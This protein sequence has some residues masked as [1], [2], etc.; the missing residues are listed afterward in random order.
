MPVK[1]IQQSLP[2]LCPVSDALELLSASGAESRG[3]VFTRKEVVDFMLD[4]AGYLPSRPLHTQRALEPSFG[5]GDFLL[6][7]VDRLLAAARNHGAAMGPAS[8]GPCIRAV[9]L[10]GDSFRAT[11][12]R[13]VSR[14][15]EAGVSSPD[16]AALAKTWL[17]E[18]DFLLS[19]F[20][21][22]FDF[23]VGNPPYVRQEMI[24][25]PLLRVYRDLFDTIYDRADLYIPFIEKSLGLLKS[26]GMLAFICSDRWMKN[27]YGSKLRRFVSNGYRLRYFVDMVDTDA[28]NVPVIAYPAITVIE[29]GGSGP[30]RLASR[31]SITKVALDSLSAELVGLHARNGTVREAE[32]VVQG[33]QPWLLG[34]S[35]ELGLVRRLEA[36]FPTLEEA[37]CQVGI[38][39]AT[40][41]DRVYIGPYDMLDVEPDRKLPLVR[42]KDI[43]SGVVNWLGFGV[44]NPFRDDGGLVDLEQYP[45][46][47]SYLLAREGII[48]ARDVARKNPSN[49]FRTIDRIY[50]ERS[51]QPKL[52]I[53][54]IKGAA[55][56]VYEEGRYYPHHNL[57]FITSES[58]DLFALK[59]VLMSGI[60]QLFV[61][62]YSTVMHG[63]FLRFQAQ[64]LRRIRAPHWRDVPEAL[65]SKLIEA[66]ATGRRE[67]CNAAVSEI[68]GLDAA[69]QQII[70]QHA[71]ASPADAN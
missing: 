47:K 8:L 56:V 30:T 57:Y 70:Y 52:L 65:R 45:R 33:E 39:V 17:V 68:Y 10:H 35:D 6:P 38:G 66:G 7:L 53:P 44:V 18:G 9:E 14:L 24:P 71:A 28:F 5:D 42:T 61:S 58:W 34:C 26:G 4:L 49:W 54:D 64:Y 40:G 69:E 51:I 55:H 23:V 43:Q 63:G 41:A 31:P 13:L 59:A 29:R 16:A 62:A 67:A 11:N 48:R 37:G 22:A 25:D 19:P 1:E 20:D 15:V 2:G 3:A 32:N 46:L 21:D 27:R 50:P 60:A 12:R 36:R